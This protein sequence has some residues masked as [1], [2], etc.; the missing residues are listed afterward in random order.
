MRFLSLFLTLAFVALASSVSRADCPGGVCKVSRPSEPLA[1]SV[2]VPLPVSVPVTAT[3]S[4]PV[5]AETVSVNHTRQRQKVRF[6][7]RSHGC[8]R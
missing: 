7:G 6:R 3:H 5:R 8:G 1:K 2:S 4:S